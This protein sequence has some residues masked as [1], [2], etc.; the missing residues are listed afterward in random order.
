MKT[1]SD[2]C[3]AFADRLRIPGEGVSPFVISSGWMIEIIRLDTGRYYFVSDGVEIRP[4]TDVFGIYYPPFSVVN[5][6]VSDVAGSINGIGRSGVLDT[7]I[8]TPVVFDIGTE[9]IFNSVT[10]AIEVLNSATNLRSIEINSLPSLIS[11]KAKRLID[12]NYSLFP[13][14][15]RI[16]ARLNV[17]QEHLSRQFKLD[18]KLSPS[19]YL[20]QLRIADAT[21]KLRKGDEIVDVSGDVG[22]NDLS[23]FYKQF[24]VTH[25]T[26][27]GNYQKTPRLCYL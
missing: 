17:S 8:T 19:R 10:D 9:R 25:K 22:Y 2:G 26:S 20:H 15:S 24:R 14:I 6:G 23:R 11:L 21:Y 16:A 27:P 3:C 18:Y 5:V 4:S 7:T 13:S 1:L 12:E